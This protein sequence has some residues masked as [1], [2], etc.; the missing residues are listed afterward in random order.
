MQH[1]RAIIVTGAFSLLITL[2]YVPYLTWDTGIR[3][4]TQPCESTGWGSAAQYLLRGNGGDILDAEYYLFLIGLAVIFV[5]LW[6]FQWIAKKNTA[7]NTPNMSSVRRDFRL[8][9]RH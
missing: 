9:R 3:C 2:L 4:I 6:V 1:L 5:I 7:E 8:N